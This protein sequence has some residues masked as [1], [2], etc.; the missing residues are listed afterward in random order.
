MTAGF[1]HDA[2]RRQRVGPWRGA[3]NQTVG[4]LQRM[5][6]VVG[7]RYLLA[8][9]ARKSGIWRSTL[10]TVLTVDG[11]RYLV[12]EGPETEWARDA[13]AAGRG[14]LRR[15]RVDEHVT[16]VELPISER[17]PILRAYPRLAPGGLAALAR[18]YGLPADA[19]AV[20]RL[21]VHWPV[22]RVERR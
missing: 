18:R 14:I 19:D 8:L 7:S 17:M 22:Y 20:A 10:V 15:G 13:R 6:F 9:P 12:A 4:L 2:A 3:V 16:L 21:A 1:S 11:E 5:G